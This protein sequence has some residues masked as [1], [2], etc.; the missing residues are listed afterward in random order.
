MHE[1]DKK[2]EIIKQKIKNEM[3]RYILYTL[4]LT[5]FFAAFTTYE[6]LLLNFHGP[7]FPYGYSLI[8]GLIMAKVVLIGETIKLGEKFSEKPLIVPVFYKTLV[9]CLFMII[10]SILEHV[11]TG[12]L[13]DKLSIDVVYE[14]FIS[15]GLSLALAKSVIVFF[16][17]IWFFSVLETS[18]V[19]GNRKLFNLFFAARHAGDVFHTK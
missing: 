16:V 2:N 13:I 12:C 15:R 19:L 14:R 6:R 17:F 9:F 11:V 7:F 5:F 4:F 1:D 18:R 3:Q 10:L 8:Q